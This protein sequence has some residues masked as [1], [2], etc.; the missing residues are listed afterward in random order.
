MAPTGEMQDGNLTES[1]STMELNNMNE[2][3]IAATPEPTTDI[4]VSPPPIIIQ[5]EITNAPNKIHVDKSKCATIIVRP[6]KSVEFTS[7][8]CAEEIL[9]DIELAS[10]PKSPEMPIMTSFRQIA[11]ESPIFF[12]RRGGSTATTANVVKT[13]SDVGVQDSPIREHAE[14]SCQTDD[15]EILEIKSQFI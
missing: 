13:H 10:R 5:K 2:E 4:P 8:V 7:Q 15:N 12:A 11:L 3:E 1:H 6:G 14:F 9:R